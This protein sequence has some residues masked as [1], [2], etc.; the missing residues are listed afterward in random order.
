MG[1]VCTSVHAFS[2]I[3]IA[4]STPCLNGFW[5]SHPYIL[6]QFWE[7]FFMLLYIASTQL[8]EQLVSIKPLLPNAVIFIALVLCR[9][10]VPHLCTSVRLHVHIRA[11]KECTLLSMVQ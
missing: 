7:V 3:S 2:F 4:P 8:Q 1:E 10:Y 5:H 11:I 9:L 6:V